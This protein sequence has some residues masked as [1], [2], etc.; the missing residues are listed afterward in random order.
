MAS[1]ML[2]WMGLIEKG[3]DYAEEKLRQEKTRKQRLK[4]AI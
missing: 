4:T 2:Q 3:N 1:L